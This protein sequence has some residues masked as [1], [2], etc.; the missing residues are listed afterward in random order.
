MLTEEQQ[1]K[2]DDIIKTRDSLS[3]TYTEEELSWRYAI[4]ENG[5]VIGEKNI[6]GRVTKLYPKGLIG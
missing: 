2:I 6:L 4:W 3:R 5:R 1:V